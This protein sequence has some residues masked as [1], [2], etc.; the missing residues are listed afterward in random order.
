VIW[1]FSGVDTTAPLDQT[2]EASLAL[3]HDRQPNFGQS[4]PQILQ[5]HE[6]RALSL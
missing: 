1:E 5:Y 3:G 4:C 2:E 6:G